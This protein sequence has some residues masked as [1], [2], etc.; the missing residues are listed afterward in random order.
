MDGTSPIGELLGALAAF[1]LECPTMALDGK[2][3][4]GKY[5]FKYLTL[6]KLINETK[7]LLAKHGLTITQ[8]P[9]ISRTG[10]VVA[11][12]TILGHSSGQH[13]AKTFEMK[14][15]QTVL[16]DGKILPVTP[17]DYGSA[18][19]YAKRYAYGSA[20]G[21]V[22]EEDK[23]GLNEAEIYQASKDDIAWLKATC[24]KLG[25]KDPKLMKQISDKM[26]KDTCTKDPKIVKGMIP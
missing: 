26:L 11:V 7:P 21:I 16:K 24:L 9:D 4:T 17:Q 2:V 15:P 3:K 22:T 20:L 14:I 1:Q 18:I 5:D 10:D 12:T 19:S 23:D 6:G 25:V 13:M 8:W